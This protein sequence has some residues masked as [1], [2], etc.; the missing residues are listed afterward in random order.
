MADDGAG[1]RRSKWWSDSSCN[2]KVKLRDL[3][4]GVREK[5]VKDDLKGGWIRPR[6]EHVRGLRAYVKFGHLEFEVPIRHL[7]G[8][9][10]WNSRERS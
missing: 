3:F 2:L 7:S 10:A 1:S 5:G 6:Q 4:V 8:H 9:F